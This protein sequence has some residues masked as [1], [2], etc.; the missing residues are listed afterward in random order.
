M[1]EHSRVKE[2]LK[3]WELTAENIAN[4]VYSGSGAINPNAFVINERYVLKAFS[5]LG[6]A[7]IN[8][9]VQKALCAKGLQEAVPIT[10]KQGEEIVVDGEFFYLLMPKIDGESLRAAEFYKGDSYAKAYELGKVIGKLH[11][12]LK[13]SDDIPC[14]ERNIYEEVCKKWLEPAM[15]ALGLNEAFKWDYVDNFGQLQEQLSVQIIHRDPNP[16]NILWKEGNCAGF[17]DF[18]LAQ[19]SIRL[20]D[21]CYAATA[22]LSES[23]EQPNEI[24]FEI[25]KGILHGYDSVAQLTEAEKKAIPYVVLSIQLICVGYFS[26]QEKFEQLAKTNVA[27]MKWL[28]ENREK[29]EWD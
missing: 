22:I 11:Q 1:I 21:P 13:E 9:Q 20:F 3:Q 4:L 19:R 18:D 29:L 17:I 27:M 8:V 5:V 15:Q 2:V 6:K 12:V 7:Q 10:T 28:L 23:F 24:W 26:Q 14:N 16:S 25:F